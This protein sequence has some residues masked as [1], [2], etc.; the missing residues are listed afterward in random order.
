MSQLLRRGKEEGKGGR[1]ERRERN[2]GS[3]SIFLRIRSLDCHFPSFPVVRPNVAR[4]PYTASSHPLASHSPGDEISFSF[5]AAHV[6]SRFL[7][8]KLFRC[9]SEERRK[10]ILLVPRGWRVALILTVTTSRDRCRI[11][12]HARIAAHSRTSA[13]RRGW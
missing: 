13:K 5:F 11:N 9:N 6:R 8:L 7:R 12:W 10:V 3:P 1:L 2:R 4:A